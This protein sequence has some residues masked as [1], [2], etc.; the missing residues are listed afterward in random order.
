MYIEL[1]YSNTDGNKI[2]GYDVTEYQSSF[3]IINF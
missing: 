3:E 1:M 2:K